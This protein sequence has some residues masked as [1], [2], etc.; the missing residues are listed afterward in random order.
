MHSVAIVNLSFPK[1]ATYYC[2]RTKLVG[3]RNCFWKL[4]FNYLGFNVWSNFRVLIIIYIWRKI[5]YFFAPHGYYVKFSMLI[6]LI[7][8]RFNYGEMLY[9][10]KKLELFKNGNYITKQKKP[11][12]IKLPCCRTILK[13]WMKIPDWNYFDFFY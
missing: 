10:C 8:K 13:I 6:F 11:L 1:C 3:G 4:H 12:F 7:D 2:T 9:F 5:F